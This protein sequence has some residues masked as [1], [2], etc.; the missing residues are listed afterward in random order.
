MAVA[1]SKPDLFVACTG[2]EIL[3]GLHSVAQSVKE[4]WSLSKSSERRWP[5]VRFLLGSFLD[6][7]EWLEGD[8]VYANSTCFDIS[9]MKRLYDMAAAGMKRGSIFV[10][11]S[12]SLPSL[13]SMEGSPCSFH[14]FAEERLEMSWGMADVFFHQKL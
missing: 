7:V 3:P 4:H 6:L 13:C 14:L 8:I 10:T 2:I 11:F 12:R 1:L 5:E 9:T